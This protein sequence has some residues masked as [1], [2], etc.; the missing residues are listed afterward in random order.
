VYHFLEDVA[1]ADVAFEVHAETLPALFRD[2]AEAVAKVQVDNLGEVK[3]AQPVRIELEQESAEMLLYHFLQE[4]IY[5]KDAKRLILLVDSAEVERV[6]GHF[7]LT[8]E[9]SGEEID[10][11]RHILNAD[12]KAV[13]MHM[14][15]V[16][17]TSE[18]WK[19]TVVLDI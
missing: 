17:E 5:Y 18:G 19:A 9:A 11:D 1:I 16:K 13:T 15:E 3:R 7:R 12:V 14:F 10:M 2:A 4:L 8:V 6:N